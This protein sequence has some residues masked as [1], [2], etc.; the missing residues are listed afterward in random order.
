M[1]LKF[2]L[3][4]FAAGLF[5]LTGIL[6]GTAFAQGNY[7]RSSMLF[8]V[9]YASPFTTGTLSNGQKFSD[10]FNSGYKVGFGYGYLL[11]KNLQLHLMFDYYGFSSKNVSGTIDGMPYSYSL[12]AAGVWTYKVGADYYLFGNYVKPGF[13]L[14]AL[15]DFGGEY[16][17]SVALSNPGG[18]ISNNNPGFSSASG[19]TADAGIG[20]SY[21]FNEWFGLYAQ[22]EYAYF[23]A[24]PH[25]SSFPIE[26]GLKYSF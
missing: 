15:G 3:F 12:N 5:F 22:G 11:R 18:Q 9:G 13:G 8:N 4:L 21:N 20:V 16:L 7:P 23:S 14:Y 26:A 24:S 10:Y 1:K 19:I 17:A 2:L 6:G 25:F